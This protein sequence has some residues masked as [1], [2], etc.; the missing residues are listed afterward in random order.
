MPTRLGICDRQLHR[1]GS[2]YPTHADQ[3]TADALL[4]AIEDAPPGAGVG[5]G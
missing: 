2:V 3:G 4:R 5:W 1:D